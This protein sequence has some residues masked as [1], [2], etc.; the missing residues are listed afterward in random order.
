LGMTKIPVRSWSFLKASALVTCEG[1]TKSMLV[2]KPT[3]YGYWLS[4]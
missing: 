2:D 1:Y 4:L 3:S